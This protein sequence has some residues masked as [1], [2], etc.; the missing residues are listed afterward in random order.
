[1][2]LSR[3]DEKPLEYSLCKRVI[4]TPNR[5]KYQKSFDLTA[6]AVTEPLDLA[7]AITSCDALAKTV[8]S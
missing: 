6:S 4:V 7:T 8:Y 3:C 5:N 1:M 2:P